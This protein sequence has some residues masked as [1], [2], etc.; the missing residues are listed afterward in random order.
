MSGRASM[1]GLLAANVSPYKV[2]LTL[3]DWGLL[4][5]TRVWSM[6]SVSL[7]VDVKKL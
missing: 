5:G 2:A 4:F 1:E 6:T 7:V 3:D